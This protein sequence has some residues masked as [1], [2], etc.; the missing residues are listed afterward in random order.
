MSNDIQAC[1]PSSGALT[2]VN[3][4]GRCVSETAELYTEPDE[5]IY[6]P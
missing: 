1:M 5:P 6:Q 3:S 4:K 2:L